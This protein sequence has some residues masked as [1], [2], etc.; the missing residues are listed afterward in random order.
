MTLALIASL[1]V[2]SCS[3]DEAGTI[4]TADT[5]SG[6]MAA[7]V[8]VEASDIA[9]DQQQGDTAAHQDDSEAETTAPEDGDPCLNAGTEGA[10]AT[11]LA[12]TQSA[13]YYIDQAER[14]F[15]TLDVTADPERVPTYSELVARWEWP[16]WL[17]LTAYGSQDMIDTNKALHT[18][19][20]STVPTR[21]C[22]AF[23]VQPFARCTVVFEYDDGPCPIYEEFTFNDAGEMTFIEA[24]SDIPGLRPQIDPQDP[25]GEL[26][27]LGRLATRVP[28]LGNAQGLI[29][30]ESS[31]MTQAAEADPDVAD[32]ALRASDW[33]VYWYEAFTEAPTSFFAQGCGW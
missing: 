7:D 11:C 12:P 27:S 14:Y 25:W 9:A 10:T 6:D 17:L 23:D 26:S 24:W 8:P 30:L 31:W 29:S 13:E 21:D 3:G 5:L 19:D 33:W 18:L 16:P 20:P 2:L 22:R 15:D 1:L 32:F 4:E 28:G